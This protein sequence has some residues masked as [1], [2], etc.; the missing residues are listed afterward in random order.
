MTDKKT[1]F[2]WMF[3]AEEH[4]YTFNKNKYSIEEMELMGFDLKEQV[5][6]ISKS[7]NNSI[8]N[9]KTF[10]IGTMA[11]TIIGSLISPVPAGVLGKLI[12]L[13][14]AVG[15]LVF[16]LIETGR[17]GKL[18]KRKHEILKQMYIDSFN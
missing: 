18:T 10:L 7:I 3:T 9:S 8:K 2:E 1:G 13:L 17:V 6:M 14:W 12:C 5:T 15:F 4:G 11:A 16:M